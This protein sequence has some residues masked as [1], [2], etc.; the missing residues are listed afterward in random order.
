MR[1]ATAIKNQYIRNK[2]SESVRLIESGDT[3]PRSA[4]H[5]V[6]LREK[7]VAEKDG[8][9]PDYYKNVIVDEFFGL[10][11]AGHDTTASVVAWGV[12]L[13]SDSDN[14]RVQDILRTAL[15]TELAQ[16]AR[17][18]RAPTYQ[19]LA[20][21]HVPYLD[22]VVE[23]VL[24]HVNT[25]SFVARRAQQDTTVLGCRIPR[26][27]DVFMVA[28]GAGYLTPNMR[29]DDA[30]RSPGARSGGK[31]LTGL[32]DDDG[33][34]AFEPKRWLKVNSD[35]GVETFDPMA[36]PTLAFGLGPRG[37]FGKR[38]A[39]QALRIEFALILWHFKLREVP[40]ALA[41]Y[42]GVQ[43]FAREPARCYVRLENAG[44]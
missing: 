18:R 32:W 42:E 38:L 20:G 24:R 22:A 33:V 29:T 37:C 39:L 14:A 7:A 9:K 27:T 34:A 35:T 2:V 10:V 11:A 36:G 19:E 3:N 16:A 40:D 30:M 13:L 15:R 31:A 25:V 5:S 44:F 21:A 28:N 43:K 1:K 17:E 12:K 8:R 6:L 41:G 23:E 4:L 26:G